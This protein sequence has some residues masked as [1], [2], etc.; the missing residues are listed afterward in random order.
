FVICPYHKYSHR[1]GARHM[2]DNNCQD[3]AKKK[4]EQEALFLM[5][6]T[7]GVSLFMTFL[8]VFVIAV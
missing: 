1:L 7:I 3:E 4:E 6:F 8:V 5:A 2:P